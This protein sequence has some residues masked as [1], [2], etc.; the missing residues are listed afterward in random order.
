MKYLA[1][2]MGILSPKLDVD[3]ILFDVADR[4]WGCTS[5][6]GVFMLMTVETAL[7]LRI[8]HPV[9]LAFLDPLN[10]IKLK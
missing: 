6:L 1:G 4:Q 3:I 10:S 7:R 2:Y 9:C 5:S 8:D